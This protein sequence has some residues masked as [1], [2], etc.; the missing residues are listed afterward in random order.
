MDICPTKNGFT[1]VRA[2]IGLTRQLDRHQPGNYFEP[3]VAGQSMVFGL[4][5]LKK[6][7]YIIIIYNFV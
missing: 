4:S 1:C 6:G 2:K 3:C 7:N 5:S